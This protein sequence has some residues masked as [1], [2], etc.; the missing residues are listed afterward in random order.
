MSG[1]NRIDK[2]E[3]SMDIYLCLHGTEDLH[4]PEIRITCVINGFLVLS[5]H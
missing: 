4:G 2:R 5:S 1:H 3:Q